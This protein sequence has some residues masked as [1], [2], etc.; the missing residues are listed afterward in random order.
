[1]QIKPFLALL[2]FCGALLIAAAPKPDPKWEKEIQALE[3]AS[4]QDQSAKGAVLFVG[5]SS[6]RLW[7][8]LAADFPNVHVIN[9][10]FGGSQISDCTAYADRLVLPFAPSKIFLYAGDNDIAGGKSPEQVAADFKEFVATIRK[11]LPQTPLYF[12]SIKPSPSRWALAEK[13]RAANKLIGEYIRGEKGLHYIDVFD[14]MLG[15]DGKPDPTLFREDN[16]HMNPK[17][18]AIWARII[19]KEI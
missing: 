8:S 17:G 10:G 7:N 16:L 3:K 5:S 14:S 13:V 6:I 4:S 19:G 15:P 18:Y 12:I 11:S 9:N 1:M 2:V